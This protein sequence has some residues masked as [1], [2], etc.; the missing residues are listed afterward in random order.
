MESVHF[1]GVDDGATVFVRCVSVCLS[2]CLCAAADRSLR[3]V[4]DIINVP[5]DNLYFTRN[6]TDSKFGKQVSR[7][8]TDVTFKTFSK[9]GIWP[10]SRERPPK[11]TWRDMQTSAF[12]S[13]IYNYEKIIQFNFVLKDRQGIKT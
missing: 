4:D 13:L 8:S 3:P 1:N 12:Y 2:V 9:G 11:F 10:G 6:A 5:N 7:D